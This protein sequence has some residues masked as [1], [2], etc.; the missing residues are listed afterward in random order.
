MITEDPL[1]YEVIDN[2]FDGIKSGDITPVDIS[3]LFNEPTQGMMQT[4]AENLPYLFNYQKSRSRNVRESFR[5][6]AL[7]IDKDKLAKKLP[8]LILTVCQKFRNYDICEL[9]Y[10]L[11]SS[12]M[13]DWEENLE[14]NLSHLFDCPLFYG[15]FNTRE[16]RELSRE[17]ASR[18]GKDKVGV[19]KL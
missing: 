12:V 14:E 6:L 1:F 13:Q 10:E 17:L 15:L 7:K 3:K 19:K 5:E 8:Y 9:S 18:V 11:A 2:L 16:I 4:L